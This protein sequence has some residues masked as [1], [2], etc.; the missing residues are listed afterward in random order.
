MKRTYNTTLGLV[1]AMS[2]LASPS[3]ASDP[4]ENDQSKSMTKAKAQPKLE[5]F[6]GEVKLP[7]LFIGSKAPKLQIA[8]FVKGDS[9]GDFEPGQVYVVEFWATWCGPCIA[10]FPHL[11]ELQAEH[12]GK[13]SFVGVNVWEGVDDPAQ[14]IAKVE[15][16][17]EKQGDRMSYTVAVEDGTAMAD[18]WMKPAGQNGIPAA[19]IVDGTGH[20]AWIGHPA[21]IDEPLA[22]VVKGEFDP[23]TAVEAAKKDMLLM[24]GYQKFVESLQKG[25]NLEDARQIANILINDYI[26]D[27]PAGLNAIA[28][29][30]LT[31]ESPKIGMHDYKVALR[32]IAI[33]CEK[34]SWKDW[35]LLDTYALAAM[36]TGNKAEAIKWQKKAL[37]L[38]PADNTDAVKELQA[39][40]AEYESEG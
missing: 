32:S 19:F 26:Q 30:I 35:S 38:V 36:K 33:A 1:A 39:R 25:E 18:T 28:W 27:E 15:S 13:V 2:I 16:F 40:L 17:V 22:S 21:S 9:V 23:T 3:F 12:E 37:E 4:T 7:E 24:A 10:A 8:K 6:V 5:D 14:R 29:M 11:S 31:S 34:T 20:V